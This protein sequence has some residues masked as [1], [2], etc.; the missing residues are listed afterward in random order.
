VRILSGVNPGDQVVTKGLE[1]LFDGAAVKI[2][3]EAR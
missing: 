3:A 2:D 1:Q